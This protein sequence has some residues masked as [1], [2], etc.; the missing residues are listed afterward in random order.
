MRASGWICG[1][2]RRRLVRAAVFGAATSAVFVVRAVL[3]TR[4]ASGKSGDYTT[5]YEPVARSLLEGR[6]FV[7]ANGRPA[8][9]YPP[10]YP[11]IVA[12]TLGFADAVKIPERQ[13]IGVLSALSVGLGALFVFD[14]SARVWPGGRALVA[15]ALV[16]TYPLLLWLCR[17]SSVELP[18]LA[19]LSACLLTFWMT[20]GAERG[21]GLAFLSGALIGLAMLVRPI[22]IGMGLLL[23]ILAW[24]WAKGGRGVRGTLAGMILL[25][26]ALTI[27]PWELWAFTQTGRIIPLS[28]GGVVSVRDGLAFAGARKT[29]RERHAIP[30]D[31]A[32]LTADIEVDYQNLRSLGDIVAL[33]RREAAERP[34]AVV[35]LMVW[36]AVRPLYA[37]ESRRREGAL[38][39]LQVP[40][41]VLLAWSYHKARRQGTGPARLASLLLGCFILFWLMAFLALSIVRYMVPAIVVLFAIVPAALPA[42]FAMEP[43][44]T[45]S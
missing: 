23:A 31:V 14:L 40:Y 33:L 6:G 12:G 19:L 3:P 43:G 2:A 38:A 4:A 7:L 26:N 29:W 36:K 21:L 22:A 42:R 1:S 20:L 45:R 32:D 8:L 10:G 30:P 16:A 13:A 44:L 35:K 5:F 28:S 39:L 9:R 17:Q 18:F 11:V 24:A 41:L 15:P 27:L 34:E 25:G 37:T